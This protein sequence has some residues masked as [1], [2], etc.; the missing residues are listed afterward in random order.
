MDDKQKIKK[1]IKEGTITPEQ[2]ELLLQALNESERRRQTVIND[3]KAQ[4]KSRKNKA[5]GL[6]GSILFVVLVLISILIHL[7]MAQSP[8]RDVQKAIQE[9]GQAAGFIQERNY[10]SAVESIEKGIG[11]APRF[12]LGYTMLGMTYQ[13]MGAEDKTQKFEVLASEAFDKAANLHEK[14]ADKSR[15]KITGIVFLVIFLLLI[16]SSVCLVLL[17]LYNSLVRR[18]EDVSESWALVAT[19][20]QRKLDLIPL[21]LDVVKEFVAH[22]QDTFKAVSEARAWAGSALDQVQGMPTEDAQK[23]GEI[24]KAEDALNLA[25]GRINALS[26]QYPDLKTNASYLAVQHELSDTENEIAF[27]RQTYNQKV[28]KYNAGLRTFPL[29]LM[30][31]VFGF[32]ERTYFAVAE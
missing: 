29:N 30:A 20:C 23:I 6:L 13:M 27:A 32:S 8:G 4:T 22:E 14:K 10:P 15:R 26:E 1:M 2:A 25:M 11:K 7:A 17:L 3:I 9:F 5:K 28:K 18:E 16:F 21:V 19:Y 24:G 12:F 31:A